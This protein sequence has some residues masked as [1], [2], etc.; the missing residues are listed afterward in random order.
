M[1][2]CAPTRTRLSVHCRLCL[3]CGLN[4][5]SN[6]SAFAP[7]LAALHYSTTTAAAGKT[8]E[9]IRKTFNIKVSREGGLFVGRV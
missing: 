1:M 4:I 7:S 3:A 2:H 9:E 5:L 6:N 8:P